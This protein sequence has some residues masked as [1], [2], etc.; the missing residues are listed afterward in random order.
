MDLYLLSHGF[1]L[2]SH[3]QLSRPLWR[4][5]QN[6]DILQYLGV[7]KPLPPDSA[8]FVQTSHAR[9]R[10]YETD[11]IKFAP[12]LSQHSL[13][14][15]L[16]QTWN[17]LTQA[18]TFCPCVPLSRWNWWRFHPTAFFL[19][20]T[21]NHPP[22]HLPPSLLQTKRTQTNHKTAQTATGWF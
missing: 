3:L 2:V 20:S 11:R 19:F 6:L 5:P 4:L 9:F 22:S 8:N 13:T 14:D 10:T 15:L 17:S 7:T 18:G 1:L 12:S 21:T 16:F